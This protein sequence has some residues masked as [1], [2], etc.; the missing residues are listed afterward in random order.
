MTAQIDAGEYTPVQKDQLDL[1]SMVDCAYSMA[2][3]STNQSATASASFP[4]TVRSVHCP[5]PSAT[6]PEQVDSTAADLAALDSMYTALSSLGFQQ[7]SGA[8][9]GSLFS[10]ARCCVNAHFMH[11]LSIAGLF[12]F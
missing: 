2:D 1:A 12:C 10:A 11:I 6:G 5:T 7:V 4:S 9:V 3:W 8:D